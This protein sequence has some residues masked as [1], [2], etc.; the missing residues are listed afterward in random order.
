MESELLEN[1]GASLFAT[2]HVGAGDL[3]LGAAAVGWRRAVQQRG[4]ALGG[5]GD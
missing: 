1:G 4:S 3:S 5:A 2:D